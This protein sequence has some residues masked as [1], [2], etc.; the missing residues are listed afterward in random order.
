MAG[1]E[2]GRPF[3]GGESLRVAKSLL[4]RQLESA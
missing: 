3:A 2:H 1:I 4:S